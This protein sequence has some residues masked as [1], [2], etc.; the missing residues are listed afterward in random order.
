[1]GKRSDPH[2]PPIRVGSKAVTYTPPGGGGAEKYSR[3]VYKCEIIA[4]R[5][6]GEAVTEIDGDRD[7]S[8]RDVRADLRLPD[9]S[10]V[11]GVP[12]T[13]QTLRDEGDGSSWCRPYITSMTMR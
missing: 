2:P 9:G 11:K 6:D 3:L 10:D 8:K 13:D 5:L 4:L 12:Y 1:M 7:Y